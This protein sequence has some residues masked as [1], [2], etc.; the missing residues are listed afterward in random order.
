MAEQN[1]DT[2]DQ[3]GTNESPLTHEK[4]RPVNQPSEEWGERATDAT[5]IEQG[6]KR[7]QTEARKSGEK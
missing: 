2:G 3:S 5:I 4:A 6:G 1:R 7:P